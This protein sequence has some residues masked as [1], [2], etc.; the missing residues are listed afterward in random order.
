MNKFNITFF[1]RFANQN[2]DVIL[3]APNA[4]RAGR[5][6]YRENDRK[7]Y[8]A[9]IE[10][11]HELIPATKPEVTRTIFHYNNDVLLDE[12]F[13]TH[14]WVRTNHKL[15]HKS[16]SYRVINSVVCGD[17]QHVYLT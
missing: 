11:I 16:R 13:S 7:A 2:Q 3:V 12:N 15:V 6:F 14:G 4:F 5:N 9:C 10:T 1:N 17:I 8:H